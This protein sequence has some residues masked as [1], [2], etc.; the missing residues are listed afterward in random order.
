MHACARL[1]LGSY[2]LMQRHS[3]TNFMEQL[4]NANLNTERLIISDSFCAYKHAYQ[5][6]H[7]TATHLVKGYFSFLQNPPG[8]PGS[9]CPPLESTIVV[10]MT[11]LISRHSY[12]FL[13]LWLIFTIHLDRNPYDW[14][15]AMH[16][17]CWCENDKNGRLANMTLRD[18][19]TTQWTN[20]EFFQ[21]SLHES[22]SCGTILQVINFFLTPHVFSFLTVLSL[23]VPCS[24]NEEL[25]KHEHVDPLC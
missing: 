22:G 14:V 15:A 3:G 17:Q 8:V 13:D 10:A 2:S 23:S 25:R 20:D 19:L 24:K 6:R 12:F 11:R 21:T 4:L 7:S 9:N 5:V 1:P 18:F 16:R